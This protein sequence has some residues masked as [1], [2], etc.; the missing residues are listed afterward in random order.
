MATDYETSCARVHRAFCDERYW[1]ARLAE[2]GADEARLDSMVLDGDGGIDV[3][4]TQVLRAGRLPGVVTQ[5]HRGDLAITREE[6]W[7]A[8]RDGRATAAVAGSIAGAPVAL[9]GAAELTDAGTAPGPARARLA[10]QAT[11]AVRV[12]LVGGKLEKFIGGQLLELLDAE[13]RFTTRW[14]AENHS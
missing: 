7:T 1:L 4:T 8:L 3:V 10:L 13:Q 14:I 9:A 2:S 5:F 6:T 11:V 12:P